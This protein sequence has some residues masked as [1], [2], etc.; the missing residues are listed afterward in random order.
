MQYDPVKDVILKA[1][2]KISYLRKSFFVTLDLLFLRQWYVKARIKRWFPKAKPLSFFDAG[3][4]FCQY[5]DFILSGWKQSTAFAL[6]LKTDYLKDFN[7]YASRKYPQR[8]NW[9]SSDLVTYHPAKQY[10]LI[11]AIDILEHIENDRQVLSNFI[12]ALKP[13]GK[14]V[15]ST[16]SDLDET[17]RFTAEHVRPGYAKSEMQEKLITAGFVIDSLDYSYGKWG[18]LSWKLAIKIPL[19]LVSVSKIMLLLLPIYYICL[20]P[21]IYLLMRI[22]IK[23]DNKTGN[24]LVVVA[25]KPFIAS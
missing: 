14:L 24:G 21:L 16:P 18:H 10:D 20:Y 19:L 4:G 17:A 9:I 13:G 23:S 15:I 8:F 7:E 1:V 3:A 12:A 22:D 5:S 11:A 25:E 2:R 6:D